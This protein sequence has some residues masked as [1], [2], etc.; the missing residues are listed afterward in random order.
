MTRK[1]AVQL[2]FRYRAMVLGYALSILRDRH[3]AEDLFQEVVLVVLDKFDSIRSEEAFPAWVRTAARFRALK[4]LRDDKSRPVVLVDDRVLDALEPHWQKRESDESLSRALDECLK[5]LTAR[6]RSLLTL[7]FADNWN[8]RDIARREGKPAHTIHVA[9]SRI[10]D[11]LRRCLSR[12]MRPG[13]EFA[14]GS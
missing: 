12:E 7:R 2:L 5:R 3:M 10:Y 1:K 9:F 11:S 8:C 14:H 6:A 13:G 4:K